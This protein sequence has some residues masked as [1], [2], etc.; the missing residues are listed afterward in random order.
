[1]E[2]GGVTVVWTRATE[3]DLRALQDAETAS[4]SRSRH[5]E[6]ATLD[7]WIVEARSRGAVIALVAN[8][9][10]AGRALRAGADSVLR[11]GEATPDAI[12]EAIR[13]GREMASAR[14][15][16]SSGAGTVDLEPTAFSL[17]MRAL[18]RQ[19]ADSLTSAWSNYESISQHLRDVRDLQAKL[20][21]WAAL[22]APTQEFR[23][24]HG[25]A[26]LLFKEDVRAM[27][28]TASGSLHRAE[29]ILESA[30]ILSAP[31]SAA[32]V[33]VNL[34]L[35]EL[36][37][38]LRSEV[39][40]RA[41]LRFRGSS[42]C[43]VRLPV[44]FLVCLVTTIIAGILDDFRAAS[45]WDGR[46]EIRA[47]ANDGIVIIE[48]QDNGPALVEDLDT[49]ST[50]LAT[51]G[52]HLARVRDRIRAAGGEML[53]ESAEAGTIARVYLSVDDPGVIS[54]SAPERR[55]TAELARRTKSRSNRS[56]S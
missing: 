39:S 29:T 30:Q 41:T 32:Q 47:A 2:A 26:S 7:F 16:K 5:A 44:T 48:V 3:D 4:G 19:V 12:A 23:Q 45:Q 36:V 50:L 46:I 28:E 13:L 6:S 35:E 1:V 17:L 51:R 15:P 38:L 42:P 25:R 33:D 56:K 55:P 53:V 52:G 11:T 22:A 27:L 20:E 14:M 40:T 8:D 24:L 9:N 10:E 43:S 34:I 49:C 37:E 18:C 31:K 54:P 21:E